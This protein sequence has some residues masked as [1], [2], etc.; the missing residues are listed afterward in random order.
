MIVETRFSE[1]YIALWSAKFVRSHYCRN[2]KILLMKISKSNGDPCGTTADIFARSL[3]ELFILQRWSLFFG[4]L[5]IKLIALL[6]KPYASSFSNNKSCLRQSKANDK[7]II[8]PIFDP[9]FS[10]VFQDSIILIRE[11]CVLWFFRK[12]VRYLENLF[13]M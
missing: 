8:N 10:L 4:Y 6:P 7:I 13:S 1:A 11:F 2:K 9:L 3:N 12:P 5:F